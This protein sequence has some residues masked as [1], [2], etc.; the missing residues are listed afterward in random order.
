MRSYKKPEI[1]ISQHTCLWLKITIACQLLSSKSKPWQ[2][3]RNKGRSGREINGQEQENETTK[4][5]RQCPK[6]KERDLWSTFWKIKNRIKGENPTTR[7]RIMIFTSCIIS[8]KNCLSSTR[9]LRY[10]TANIYLL[11]PNSMSQFWL[12]N[13]LLNYSGDVLIY[14]HS[15][16]RT[17]LIPIISFSFYW[18]TNSEDSFS[19]D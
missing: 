7:Q 13:V 16:A 8:N 4:R 17:S 2:Y 6:T 1:P 11:W 5:Q 15:Y 3:H 14:A 19:F 12:H 18:F 10:F 9:N